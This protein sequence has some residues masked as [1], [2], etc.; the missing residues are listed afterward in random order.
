[1]TTLEE[2]PE[3]R[4]LRRNIK[5]LYC[6]R[7]QQ[8]ALLLVAVAVPFWQ[9]LGLDQTQIYLLQSIFAAACVL[10]EMPSGWFA[11][12]FGRRHCLLVSAIA[13]PTG[14]L[15]FALANSFTHLALAEVLLGVGMAFASGADSALAFESMHAVDGTKGYR[16]FESRALAVSTAAEAL[17]AA[18]GGLLALA[19][20]R[21]PIW[22]QVALDAAMLPVVLAL[23]EP[24]R[25]REQAGN[26]A[27]RN[28][29]RDM[30]A[31]FA[32][33]VRGH[34]QIPWLLAASAV[35]N[36][37]TYLAVWLVQPYYQQAGVPLGWFGV[38]WAVQLLAVASFAPFGARLEL[39]LGRPATLALL[40]AVGAGTYAALAAGLS[41]GVAAL[42]LPV[43]LGF[44][45]VRA[46]SQP[47]MREAVNNRVGSEIRASLLSV[48]S[49]LHRLAYMLLGPLVGYIVD[50]WGLRT[51]L[52]VL[53]LA[54]STIGALVL[55]GGKASRAFDDDPPSH[56][57]PPAS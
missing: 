14:F 46:V 50:R 21:A 25:A 3:V 38:L 44:A 12:A 7:A 9:S 42:G 45:L 56:A 11:D 2:H 47:L 18:A 37:L 55:A 51:G 20:L 52:A 35:L 5:L 31:A 53:A 41:F 36:T 6:V 26:P 29:V 10:C 13:C 34:R 17:A 40:V 27:R 19:S 15:T 23:R 8:G 28:P 24:T 16:R 1:M 39:T 30:A 43:L 48:Q 33:A 49:L 32:Y 22:G 57:E 54:F 4:E